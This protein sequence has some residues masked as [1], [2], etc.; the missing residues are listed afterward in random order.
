MKKQILGVICDHLRHLR[1]KG[2]NDPGQMSAH[3]TADHTA[4][5]AKNLS[6]KQEVTALFTENTE[7]NAW[8]VKGFTHPSP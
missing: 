7:R 3:S 4:R 5:L 6:K 2:E 1:L 8:A